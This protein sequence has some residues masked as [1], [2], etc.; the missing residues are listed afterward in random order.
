MGQGGADFLASVSLSSE[1][2]E[3]IE[4]TNR[5][6]GV[7]FKRL[8]R[9]DKRGWARSYPKKDEKMVGGARV[10]RVFRIQ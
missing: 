8:W 9:L 5:G 7:A 3:I 1:H 4:G 6:V 2:L 10:F